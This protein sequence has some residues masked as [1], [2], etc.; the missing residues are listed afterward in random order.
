MTRR[1]AYT[2]K[3]TMKTCTKCREAKPLDEFSRNKGSRDG[4]RTRCKKCVADY[5]RTYHAKHY[6][7]NRAKVIEQ[8]SA[9]YAAN[10]E[11]LSGQRREYRT[12]NPHIGWEGRYRTRSRLYGYA[13]VVESFT[14]A[15]LIARY[16]DQCHHCGGPFEEL[17]HHPT[18]VALGGQHTL[19]NCRP[20]CMDCNRAPIWDIRR[21]RDEAA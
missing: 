2:E 13:P 9:Y 6:A 10:R 15:E 8:T 17:D 11:R 14:R 1:P 12:A 19:E 3:E 4:R 18:P 21:A 7:E 20:S 5:N 16:G